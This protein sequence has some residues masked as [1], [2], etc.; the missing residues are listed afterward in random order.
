ML[1]ALHHRLQYLAI[2]AFGKVIEFLPYALIEWIGNRLG[3]LLYHAF[4]K[5]RKR[6]LSNLSL[7]TKLNLNEEELVSIA[8]KSLQSLCITFLQ[9][10]KIRKEKNMDHLVTCVNPRIAE[11]LIQEGKGIVFLCAHQANWELF[12]LEGCLRMPGVAIGRP[13]KNTSLYDYVVSIR[14][15]FGGQ[16]I[17]PKQAL[18]EG[19]RA[20]KQ[21]KFLGIVGDQGMPESP[22]SSVF[23]GRK[24]YTTTAPALLAY[25]TG[26]ALI[27]ATM[28][29]ENG[30][31]F[32]TYSDPLFPNLDTPLKED[33]D[34]LMEKSLTILENSIIEK[35]EEWMWIHNR[36]K[37]ETANHVFYRYRQDSILFILKSF[38]QI[39]FNL[40]RKLYP[41][42]FITVY[43]E[44]KP[45][46]ANELG[47]E[48]ICIGSRDSL[49]RDYRFKLVFN[50]TEKPK[51]NRYFKKLAALDVIDTYKL[52]QLLKAR[53]ISKKSTLTHDLVSAIAR[54][55]QEWI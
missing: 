42:A 46:A 36:F 38:D 55:P 1:K 17:P 39:D 25:K 27:V 14:E 3:L 12:F 16:I 20:L 4:P 35:P 19:L 9:Y 49:K 37:Q 51:I 22:F 33:V 11:T 10:P 23:L 28:K 31:Y 18:K 52:N 13:I 34:R 54:N 32:I 41:K 7:A 21:G 30:R 8:K 48:V 15:R 44:N 47:I 43:V 24:A 53:Q 29:R 5:F 50:F 2:K 26:S 40:V 45:P 6:A